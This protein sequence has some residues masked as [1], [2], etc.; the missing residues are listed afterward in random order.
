MLLTKS[1]CMCIRCIKSVAPRVCLVKVPFLAFLGGPDIITEMGVVIYRYLKHSPDYINS[2]L[3]RFM[4]L[5]PLVQ[6]FLL[7][8][9]FWHF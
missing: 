7:K 6:V 9:L 8:Y 5:T 4:G 3:Y 2:N 1:S